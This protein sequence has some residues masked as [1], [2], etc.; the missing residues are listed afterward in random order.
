[1]LSYYYYEY[2]ET[3]IAFRPCIQ[4]LSF[5]SLGQDT[6]MSGQWAEVIRRWLLAIERDPEVRLL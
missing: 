1:M 3:M 4:C 5:Q 2:C 6:G